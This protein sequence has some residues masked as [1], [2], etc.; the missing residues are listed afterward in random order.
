MGVIQ[1]GCEAGFVLEAI[2][3]PDAKAWQWPSP[4]RCLTRSAPVGILSGRVPTGRSSRL[5]EDADKD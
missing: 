4:D 2:S 5:Y 1:G 3:D